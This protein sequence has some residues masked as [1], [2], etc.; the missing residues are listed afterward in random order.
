[1]IYF[2]ET[3]RASLKPAD[4]PSLGLSHI[5]D[6][7][8]ALNCVQVTGK[9]PGGKPGLLVCNKTRFGADGLKLE[10]EW[11]HPLPGI[12]SVVRVAWSER[13]TPEKLARKVQ[14]Q[15]Y[16]VDDADG[17]E[18]QLPLV[19]KVDDGGCPVSTLPCYQTLNAEGEVVAG[20]PKQEFLHLWEA[21][22]EPWGAL[23]ASISYE[24]A[25]RDAIQA[26]EDISQLGPPPKLTDADTLRWLTPIIAANYLVSATELMLLNTFD[27]V[28][29][30]PLSWV[31]LAISFADKMRR[32]DAMEEQKKTADA[33]SRSDEKTSTSPAGEAA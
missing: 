21:T 15:G 22:E 26:G 12:E 16:R 17:R 23:T 9:T 7:G 6:A 27:T 4:L 19:R 20:S 18:W 30:G 33:M 2:V 8:E 25:V 14:L 29:R 31:S 24:R 11:S 10:H 13:P 1:M 28:G 3:T 5:L 32:M